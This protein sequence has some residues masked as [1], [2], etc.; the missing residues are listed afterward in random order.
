MNVFK[1]GKNFSVSGKVAFFSKKVVLQTKSYEEILDV[2]QNL[3]H[4]GKLIP[5][6]P[7]TS[8][9]TSKWFRNRI[10]ELMEDIESFTDIMPKGV[11][12]QQHLLPLSQAFKAVHLPSDLENA[13]IGK[14]RLAFDELFFTHLQVLKRKEE[15]T[16]K[17]TAMPIF[18][19]KYKNDIQKAIDSLPFSLTGSQQKALDDIFS[20]FAKSTPMNRLLEGDVGSGKTIVAALC[21]YLAYKNG[22]Q[23]VLMAP[24]EIL[25]VQ[26]FETISKILNPLGVK[27]ILITSST[28]KSQKTRD[29]FDIAIGTHAILHSRLD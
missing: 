3:K 19:E 14:K 7:E 1:V 2:T 23:S 8:G 29:D 5:V 17:T 25:A 13:E 16:Q 4:T 9:V 28:K 22:F 26:H 12:L 10:S 11:L 18:Y 27:T 6:Y 21:L 20:D 24:T 15:W